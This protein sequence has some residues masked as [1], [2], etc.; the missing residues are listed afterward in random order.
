M[1]MSG[2]YGY[3]GMIVAS[4]RRPTRRDQN[5]SENGGTDG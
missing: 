2:V 4:L 5:E 3:N 1:I